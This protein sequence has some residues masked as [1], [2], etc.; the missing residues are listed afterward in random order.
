[1]KKHYV[2]NFEPTQTSYCIEVDFDAFSKL[3]RSESFHAG[4]VKTHEQL[5]VK[6]GELSGNLSSIDYNGHFGPNIFLTIDKENDNVLSRKKISK[7]INNHLAWLDTFPDS[8]YK[9]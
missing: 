8:V 2:K 3:I 7:L 4:F 5:D 6:L 9:D 1:M